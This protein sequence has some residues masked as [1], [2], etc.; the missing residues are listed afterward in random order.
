MPSPPITLS[1]TAISPL[2]SH[3]QTDR[4]T[5]T[6]RHTDTHRQ[7]DR[8]THT[9]RQTDR[10]TH[11]QQTDRQTHKQT[12]THT[13][14]HRQT[15]TQ[16]DRH[17]NTHTHN[18]RSH[19]GPRSRGFL[20]QQRVAMKRQTSLLDAWGSPS[21]KAAKDDETHS[22]LKRRLS[23]KSWENFQECLEKQRAEEQAVLVQ[24]ASER[25]R[26]EK[27]TPGQTQDPSLKGRGVST[28]TKM[29]RPSNS[30]YKK[31]GIK[32]HRREL[33]GQFFE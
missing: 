10:H 8:Q 3:T 33:G 29:G 11:T 19:F 17:A 14:T 7:T 28:T 2:L 16:T 32:N 24:R 22:S 30:V 9:H 12:D 27:L 26:R 15:D 20:E 31:L 6:D 23:S 4:H 18:S 13:D 25:E 21:P 1:S 5:H